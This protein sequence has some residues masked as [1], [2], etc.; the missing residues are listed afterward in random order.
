[1]K[2]NIDF[3]VEELIKILV[4]FKN[5]DCKNNESIKNLKTTLNK[6]YMDYIKPTLIPKYLKI[7]KEGISETKTIYIR[8][9]DAEYFAE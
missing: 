9:E 8:E 5:I 3:E 2:I 6:A 1:M 4:E 7:I